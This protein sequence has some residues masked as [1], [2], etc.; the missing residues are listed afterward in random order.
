MR[1]QRDEAH[2]NTPTMGYG[3]IIDCPF[4]TVT[5]AFYHHA[6]TRPAALAVRDM[7]GQCR[8]LTYQQLANRAQALATRLLSMGVQPSHRVPLVVK[9]G[10]EMIVGI[11]AILSCGAQYVP[12][13]GGV[14]PDS[15]IRQVIEQSDR[16]FALCLSSTNDR[17]HALCP[18]I[19]TVIIDDDQNEEAVEAKPVNIVDLATPD[20]GCY[21]IYT[22]GTTNN[23]LSSPQPM[24]TNSSIQEPLASRKV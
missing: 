2:R 16:Q 8:E 19:T 21:V 11:W 15:T 12:L 24:L 17:L 20:N 18:G 4:S 13:D 7:S 3:E 6:G 22:S 23:T 10:L 14:V 5:A 1:C 9:R